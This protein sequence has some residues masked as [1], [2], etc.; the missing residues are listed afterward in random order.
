MDKFYEGLTQL[1]DEHDIKHLEELPETSIV[2]SEVIHG[3]CHTLEN[4]LTAP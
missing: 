1:K 3:K 4:E 2:I